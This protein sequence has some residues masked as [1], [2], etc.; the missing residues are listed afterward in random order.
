MLW[1]SSSE[2]LY[3]RL[4]G[5]P[6]LSG[7]SVGR[8]VA[9]TG[10]T[11]FF[12]LNCHLLSELLLNEGRVGLAAFVAITQS[13]MTAS[14]GGPLGSCIDEERS[15]LRYVVRIAEFSESSS[16]RTHIAPSWTSSKA[17]PAERR[18]FFQRAN[19]AVSGSMPACPG[20]HPEVMASTPALPSTS[21]LAART[22]CVGAFG[23]ASV[24]SSVMGI[25]ITLATSARARQ[26]A[27]LKHINK[28]RKRNQP[29]F[30][31]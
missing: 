23:S 5:R 11:V 19:S 1:Q 28:R 4:Y 9:V 3:C 30:P 2:S 12:S 22:W 13:C 10:Q 14:N 25:S 16:L 21:H 15:K 17:R 31:Q 18:L 20:M 24:A 8:V 6:A 29:G 27:E 7:E 26:P